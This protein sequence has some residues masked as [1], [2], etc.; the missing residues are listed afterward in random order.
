MK[1]SSRD[2]RLL[3][4]DAKAFVKANSHRPDYVG[5]FKRCL[6]VDGYKING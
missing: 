1:K 4:R 2:R 5:L 3:L 6:L